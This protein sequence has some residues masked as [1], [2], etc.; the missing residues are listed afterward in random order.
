M[1]AVWISSGDDQPGLS[2][3]E[4]AMH[5]PGE[6]QAGSLPEVRFARSGQSEREASGHD[7]QSA[8]VPHLR[9]LLEAGSH[10]TATVQFVRLHASGSNCG[11]MTWPT[12][13]MVSWMQPAARPR[14][15]SRTSCG[16]PCDRS[17]R[18]L[19]PSHSLVLRESP[20]TDSSLEL[21]PF[22]FL[23]RRQQLF[24]LPRQQLPP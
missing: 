19:A 7:S 5:G 24:L 4:S 14:W 9:E 12:N 15:R 21:L 13:L 1:R 2:M 18:G 16:D 23:L 20:S 6:R 17:S 10:F 3:R 22:L 11:A 8:A